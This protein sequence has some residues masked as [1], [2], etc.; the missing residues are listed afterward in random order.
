MPTQAFCRPCGI[1]AIEI[2]PG[3]GCRDVDALEKQVA[4]HLSAGRLIARG[5]PARPSRSYQVQRVIVLPHIAARI[6]WSEMVR[7]AFSPLPSMVRRRGMAV[8]ASINDSDP[9]VLMPTYSSQGRPCRL[10]RSPRQTR[11]SL[12][13]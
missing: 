3:H 11:R 1:V 9:D 6:S 2:A 10:S 4:R 5:T 13:H 8:V 7:R 12:T